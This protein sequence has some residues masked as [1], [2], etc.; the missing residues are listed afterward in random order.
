MGLARESSFSVPGAAQPTQRRRRTIEPVKSAAKARSGGALRRLCS[1]GAVA[2][3]PSHQFLVRGR[4]NDAVELG[5]IARDEADVLDQDIVDEP[6]IRLL[7]QARLNWYLRPI[8]GHDQCPHDRTVAVDFLPHVLDL[9]AAVLADPG[10][11][12]ALEEIP[13]QLHKLPPLRRRALRPV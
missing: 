11:V 9:P 6:A 3:E 1:G 7:Q 2:L 10:Q 12:P 5:P 8:L 4:P 13:E